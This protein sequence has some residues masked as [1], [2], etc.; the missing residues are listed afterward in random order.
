MPS[1][2]RYDDQQDGDGSKNKT[3]NDF[4]NYIS[5]IQNFQE[6]QSAFR[7]LH[8]LSSFKAFLFLPILFEE[9]YEKFTEIVHQYQPA[10]LKLHPLQ[11]FPIKKVILEPYLQIAAKKKIPIYIHTDWVPSAEYGKY[12]NTIKENFGEITALFPEI[13]FIMG[14]AGNSDSWV[15][16]WRLIQKHPNVMV[17]TSM[18]PSPGELEKVVQNIG[19]ERV[20]FGSNFPFCEP[21][22]ELMKII[23]MNGV[24]ESD[25]ER[26]VFDNAIKLMGGPNK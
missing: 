15:N 17:E 10:G 23:M 13:T 9:P 1:W 11:N 7:N 14:H 12:R 6:I 22:V 8:S 16:I 25:K 26:I 24:S 20:L 19:I 3:G 21:S 5:Y 4:G 2:K 18:A